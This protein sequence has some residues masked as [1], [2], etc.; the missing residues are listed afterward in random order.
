MNSKYLVL[1]SG[2]Q[3]SVTCLLDLISKVNKKDICAIL[4]LYDSQVKQCVERA[5]NICK[6]LQIEHKIFDLSVLSELSNQNIVSARNLFFLAAAT[7]YAKNNGFNK[8]VIG[9]SKDDYECYNDC[10]KKFIDDAN[11]LFDY[12]FETNIEILSPLLNLTKKE[13]WA[14]A[15]SLGK[16]DFVYN[17]TYSCWENKEKECGECF[18]CKLKEKSYNEY[19]KSKSTKNQLG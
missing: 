13:I 3:D 9:L 11:K 18:S 15:D 6:N 10:K 17:N 19:I 12:A 7:L 16:L 5:K 1:L 2:G 14:L 4:F 8:I